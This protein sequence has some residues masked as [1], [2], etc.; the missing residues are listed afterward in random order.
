MCLR[1]ASAFLSSS[2]TMEARSSWCLKQVAQNPSMAVPSSPPSGP[3]LSAPLSPAADAERI[4]LAASS[5]R[6][7]RS[8][9]LSISAV[10]AWYLASSAARS[11]SS[12]SATL[13]RSPCDLHTAPAPHPAAAGQRQKAR[14]RGVRANLEHAQGTNLAVLEGVDRVRLHAE[15]L[16]LAL[17][18]R[19][20]GRQR[21]AGGG[22]RQRRSVR[23]PPTLRLS[24]GA[25]TACVAGR[26]DGGSQKR[27]FDGKGSRRTHRRTPRWW[28][29]AWRRHT[30]SG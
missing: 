8:R 27:G 15:L 22:G 29:W 16:Q 4:V 20:G 1:Y 12:S 18:R 14:P 11:L 17:R 13:S 26:A 3:A 25:A 23:G 5:P 10:R 30:Q 28:A 7:K 21:R 19:S 9:F 24:A 2:K 6:T